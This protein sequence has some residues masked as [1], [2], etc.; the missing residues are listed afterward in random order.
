MS[1]VLD[2]DAEHGFRPSRTLRL[3]VELRRQLRRKRTKLLLGLVAL[4]PV[5]L[6]VAFGVGG[7]PDPEQRGSTFADLAV[8]SAPNFAVFGLYVAGSFLLPLVVAS[9]FGDAV[10]GEA[11]WSTLKYL[12]AIPVPRPRLLRQKALAAGV[13]STGALLLFPAMSLLVGVVRY[14]AGDATSPAGDA[15]PFGESVL[16]LAITGAYI[17]VQLAW[18]AGLALLLSVVFDSPLAAVGGGVLAA[19]LSQILDAITAL[20][21]AREYLPTHYAFAWIDVFSASVDWT[22]M[23]NGTL[24]SL[25]YATALGVLAARRFSRKDITS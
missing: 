16:A 13:L 7:D 15:V 6:V 3:G 23:A 1:E 25:V 17:V 4:L 5:V 9:F 2:L 20:G 11:S 21:A 18:M 24:L 8:V 19:V 22:N 14:G 12:L 10:A